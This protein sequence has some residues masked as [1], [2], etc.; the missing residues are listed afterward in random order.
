M[1]STTEKC[2]GEINPGVLVYTFTLRDIQKTTHGAQLG[3]QIAQ[4]NSF[5]TESTMSI[6]ATDKAR[7]R[8]ILPS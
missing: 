2:H 6:Y 7:G 3:P 4:N 8:I 5:N 1:F